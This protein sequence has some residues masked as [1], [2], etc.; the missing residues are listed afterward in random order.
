MPINRH[1][2]LKAL[3]REH[4]HG[5]LLCW[6]IK[7]GFKNGIAANRIKKYADWMF[8]TH[9]LPHFE[10]EETLVFPILSSDNSLIKQAIAEHIELKKLFSDTT[11]PEN[12]LK[13]IERILDNHIRFE[14]RILFN[15]IE[16]VASNEQL[17]TIQMMHSE[18]PFIDN[19][20][21]QFWL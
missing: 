20:T 5:L 1:E 14:E 17:K 9:L 13:Q 21:D 18:K 7:T 2:N 16:N 6:K 10:L 12:S 3:S 11:N 8:E 15:E 19:T 4:H